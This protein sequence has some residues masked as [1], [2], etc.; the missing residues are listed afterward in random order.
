MVQG[1]LGKFIL[2]FIDLYSLAAYNFIIIYMTYTCQYS[3]RAD[4]LGPS[5]VYII[6]H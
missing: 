2:F 6:S 5:P 1:T 3:L 4:T